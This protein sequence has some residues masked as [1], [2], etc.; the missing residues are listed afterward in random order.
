MFLTRFVG[1]RFLAA[2]SAR[3]ESTTAAAAASTI[4]TPTNP[5]EEFFEFDRSQDEDKPV[6]YGSF[7]LFSATHLLNTSLLVGLFIECTVKK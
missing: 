1:R 7:S 6:V 2:A 5:L 3:S 4:R